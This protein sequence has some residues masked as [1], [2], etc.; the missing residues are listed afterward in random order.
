[1][2]RAVLL[3]L[4][5][6]ALL[7]VWPLRWAVT[8]FPA[9]FAAVE[10]GGA[11]PLHLLAESLTAVLC[12]WAAREEDHPP[13]MPTVGFIAL[14]TLLYGSINGL[15]YAAYGDPWQAGIVV[16]KIIGSAALLSG[17]ARGSGGLTIV[18]PRWPGWLIAFTGL[19]MIAFWTLQLVVAEIMKDGLWA[20][21]GKAYLLFHIVAELL[22][23]V[24][25]LVGG[26]GLSLRR[27]LAMSL[28]LAGAGGV[29]YAAVNSA[30]W[31]VLND[32]VLV[33]VLLFCALLV[34][35]AARRLCSIQVVAPP[36][37]T[38]ECT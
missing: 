26:I 23:G 20:V 13:L 11:W 12:W 28:C 27:P 34:V 17:L 24:T 29:L 38:R 30:G 25:A 14:G 7:G 4:I 3:R 22:A 19:G 10:G 6:V 9:G 33:F 37:L 35:V 31:A 5:G 36:G 32:Q 15:S 8:Q 21:E 18:A 2:S 1:M 16:A